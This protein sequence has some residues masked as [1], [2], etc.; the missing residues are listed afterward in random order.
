MDE[1]MRN[2]WHRKRLFPFMNGLK[3][4]RDACFEAVLLP[5]PTGQ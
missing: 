3:Y 4:T 2:Q 5:E 1:M